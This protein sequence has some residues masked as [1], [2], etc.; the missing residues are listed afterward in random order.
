MHTPS[1]TASHTA[2]NTTSQTGSH[3]AS[4]LQTPIQSKG[5]SKK[6]TK[7]SN[8]KEE[9]SS[10]IDDA[11]SSACQAIAISPLDL[12][13]LMEKLKLIEELPRLAFLRLIERYHL[14]PLLGEISVFLKADESNPVYLPLIT[15]DGWIK[16]MNA[17]PAFQGITFQEAL[18]DENSEPSWME[19]TI[20]RSD[21]IHPITV[22]EY[23][24][25]VK[26]N[27]PIWHEMPMRMLRHKVLTQTVRLAFGISMG[28][29]A[30]LI[31]EANNIKAKN[32][33]SEQNPL[34][35]VNL[36]AN[37]KPRMQLL[38]ER[39]MNNQNQLKT[40]EGFINMDSN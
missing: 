32:T 20:F 12:K 11:L 23:F 9:G 10:M 21:R 25:E 19:C 35:P 5:A 37:S 14:D 36:E 18:S 24:A 30:N 34:V 15:I 3:T 31:A 16:I 40:S 33:G 13:A 39:L 17:Q 28:E 22:R 2:S 4:I 6:T 1:H 7:N 8:L 38:K 26:T 29:P 27:Q